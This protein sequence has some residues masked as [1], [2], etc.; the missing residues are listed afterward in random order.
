MLDC[1]TVILVVFN[2]VLG[3]GSL[4]VEFECSPPHLLKDNMRCLWD[5]FS[6]TDQTHACL[7]LWKTPQ[8]PV[9]LCE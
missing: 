6:P 8:S 4:H 3:S 5:Q 1:P 9:G 2:K 7:E